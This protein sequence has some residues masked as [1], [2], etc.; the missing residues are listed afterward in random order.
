MLFWRLDAIFEV[1]DSRSR[2]A[3]GR[4]SARSKSQDASIEA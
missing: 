3:S 4:K 2:R 1:F